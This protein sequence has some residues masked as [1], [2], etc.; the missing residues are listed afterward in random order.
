MIYTVMIQIFGY[1]AA[2][3]RGLDFPGKLHFR[4]IEQHALTEILMQQDPV[5]QNVWIHIHNNTAKYILKK[6]PSQ[7]V[8]TYP[9]P[10]G[11]YVRGWECQ[12]STDPAKIYSYIY[13]HVGSIKLTKRVKPG[14]K[15]P[16]YSLFGPKVAV[17]NFLGSMLHNK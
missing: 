5:R 7:R 2:I 4:V 10:T 14:K 6:F 9:A 17:V 1:L 11:G 12:H 16:Y 13:F 8:D 3:G 15:R